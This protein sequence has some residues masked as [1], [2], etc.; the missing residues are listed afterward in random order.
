M[1]ALSVPRA[2]CSPK[3]G[4]LRT[5]P[6]IGGAHYYVSRVIVGGTIPELGIATIGIAESI[7]P[8]NFA[9]G[10]TA[11]VLLDLLSGPS[12]DPNSLNQFLLAG[13]ATIVDLVGIGVGNIVAHEAG[14]FFA[15]FHTDNFNATPN[16][17][18]QGGN[19]ANTVGV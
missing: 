16:I 2:P 4:L 13:G 8:G 15:N 9:T 11:V 18:D 6:R 5:V 10:E 14:H 12:F 7:D 19:L 3:Q 1:I 17:M